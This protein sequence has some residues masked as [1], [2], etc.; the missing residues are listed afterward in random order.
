MLLQI[1]LWNKLG[2]TQMTFAS[3]RLSAVNKVLSVTVKS[4]S[5][6]IKVTLI[7]YRSW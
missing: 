3:L 4:L 1:V 2:L 6:T 7:R 5:S